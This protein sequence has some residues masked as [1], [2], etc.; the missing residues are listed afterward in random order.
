MTTETERKFLVDHKIWNTVDKQPPSTITQG[1]LVISPSV[2]VRVRITETSDGGNK[3]AFL[4]I[5]GPRY[6]GISCEENEVQLSIQDGTRLMSQCI[7]PL[8]HKT[9]HTILDNGKIWE[10]D[11]FLNVE[12][13]GLIIAELE[14]VNEHSLYVKPT[15]AGIEVST[16]INYT[17][18]KLSE[19]LVK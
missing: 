2:T 1:Y 7:T 10:V 4:T 17:N 14:L 5:K 6:L 11:T 19:K 16:D 15:W 9:R 12:F 13:N 18:A 8:I 3:K